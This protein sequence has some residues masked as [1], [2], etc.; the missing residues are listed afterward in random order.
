MPETLV[1]PLAH[2]AV[3]CLVIVIKLEY[4]TSFRP[5]LIKAYAVENSAILK[6]AYA[7]KVLDSFVS[8]F[9][10]RLIFD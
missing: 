2:T 4:A 8:K 7:A 5:E 1:T 9:K 3:N 6:V 10:R